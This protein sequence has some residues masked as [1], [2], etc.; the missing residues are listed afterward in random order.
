MSEQSWGDVARAV[1]GSLAAPPIEPT[2][3]QRYFGDFKVFGAVDE[4]V[5][6]V[7]HGVPVNPA[8]TDVDL[9]RALQNGNYRSFI[10]HS[11]TIWKKIGEDV[12]RQKCLVVQTSAAHE[13]PNPRVSPLTAVVTHKVRIISEF[14]FAQRS[15]ENKGGL[16]RDAALNTVPQRC[17]LKRCRRLLTLVTLRKRS[18]ERG[19]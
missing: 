5:M 14:S 3:I 12:G 2:R 6:I 11:P 16:N 8:A 13:I 1:G 10:E 7:T 18:L 4:L 19:Y 15:R 9:E 17:A